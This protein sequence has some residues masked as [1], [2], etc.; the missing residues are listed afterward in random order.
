MERKENRDI[1]VNLYVESL[2]V[3]EMTLLRVWILFHY[4]CRAGMEILVFLELL[5]LLARRYVVCIQPT[6]K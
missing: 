2:L 3:H 1:L 5:D 6:D 4:F